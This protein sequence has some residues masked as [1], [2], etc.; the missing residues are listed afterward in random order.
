ML[1]YQRWLDV[2]KCAEH[3]AELKSSAHFLER[4]GQK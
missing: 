4:I 2:K 3:C 1:S